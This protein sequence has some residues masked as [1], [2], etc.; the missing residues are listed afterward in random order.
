MRTFVSLQALVTF[1]V[2]Q[3]QEAFNQKITFDDTDDVTAA[4]VQSGLVT[5]APSATSQA[6]NFGSLASAST[7]LVIAYQE[8]ELQLDSNTAPLVPVRPIPA[9]PPEAVYSRF[10]R[11]DQPGF[12]LWRGKITS[13][14]LSNPSSSVAASVFVAVVGNAT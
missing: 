9:N 2:D 8:V 7:L 5:L 3:V 6:F 14:F 4:V 13:L 10:Q 12:V 1:D 11:D